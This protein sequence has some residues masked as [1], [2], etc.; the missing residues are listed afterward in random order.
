MVRAG[1][2]KYNTQFDAD[3]SVKSPKYNV[4]SEDMDAEQSKPVSARHCTC[5]EKEF[6][7]S[8]SQFDAHV[9]LC[10]KVAAEGLV[11]LQILCNHVVGTRYTLNDRTRDYPKLNLTDE[12]L[13][14]EELPR[15]DP[16]SCLPAN[17]SADVVHDI[18]PGLPNFALYDSRAQMEAIED[19]KE[20]LSRFHR[21]N[22]I[23]EPETVPT[24]PFMESVD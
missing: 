13:Q 17:G 8:H 23:N 22:P 20:S 10:V 24:T 19:M 21:E 14:V 1:K 4:H 5:C 18:P 12:Q 15:T 11:N 9:K 16:F 2:R 7:L 3:A 6:M